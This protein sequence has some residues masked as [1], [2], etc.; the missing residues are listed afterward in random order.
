PL[1]CPDCAGALQIAAE[2][3]DRARRLAIS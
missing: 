1:I 3:N 2:R